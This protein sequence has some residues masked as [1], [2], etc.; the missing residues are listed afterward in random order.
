MPELPEVETVKRGLEPVLAGRRVERVT[1]NRSD[2]RIPFPVEF[3]QQIEKKAITGIGRRAKYLLVYVE[4]AQVIVLHLGMSGQ[5][6]HM[7]QDAYEP[8]KHDHVRLDFDDGHCLI[9]RDPRRFGLMT[10]VDADEIENHP[11]FRHLGPE[12][13]GNDFHAEYLEAALARRKGAVKAALMDQ[14]LVVGVGNIYACEA[15][16]RCGISPLYP[17]NLLKKHDNIVLSVR[18]VL[19]EAI[20]S[21]GSTLRDYVRSNGDLGYFQHRFQVYGREG[22]PCRHC[23]APIARD[24]LAGRSTYFCN[25]C[26]SII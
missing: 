8:R 24:V 14:R 6:L 4:G 18:E 20:E 5:V 7:A 3:A 22:E 13:L 17:S 21:G 2:L 11:L 16:F 15:L 23:F 1:L 12:P 19:H 26:Q 25:I 9:F 10:L